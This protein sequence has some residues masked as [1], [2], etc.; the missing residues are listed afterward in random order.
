MYYTQHCVCVY[1][2]TLVYFR[3]PTVDSE[4]SHLYRRAPY[5]WASELLLD[6]TSRRTPPCELC[7]LH[8]VPQKSVVAEARNIPYDV[9]HAARRYTRVTPG[10]RRLGCTSYVRNARLRLYG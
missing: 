2:C 8:C 4:Y 9:S 7:V 6:V 5:A 1:F 10:H 3:T